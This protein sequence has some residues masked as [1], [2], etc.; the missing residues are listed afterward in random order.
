[1]A[2]KIRSDAIEKLNGSNYT[3]W[4]LQISLLLKAAK[5]WKY[6]D[7]TEVRDAADPKKQEQWEDKD[8]EAQSIIVPTLDAAQTNHIYSCNTSK[9]MFDKLRD[10]NSDSST[11]NKQHTLTKFLNYKVGKNQSP[12]QAMTEMEEMVRCLQEMKV[13]LDEAT[14]VSKVIS[15]L[16]DE[17][18][19]FKKALDSVPEASQTRTMLMSRLKKEELERKDVED[20]EDAGTSRA[21]FGETRFQEARKQV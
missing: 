13:H 21:F 2:M 14:V 5:L 11:L 3:R 6:V 20:S 19:S 1:M 7:G 8:I 9:E 18:M 4:R 16:P 17:Y 10:M 15:S 12:V